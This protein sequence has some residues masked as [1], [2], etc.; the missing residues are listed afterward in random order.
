MSIG[1]FS[2]ATRLTAKALRFYHREGLLEPAVVD[3]SNGYRFYS[4][5]QIADAQAIRA[6]RS[7]HLP[8]DDVRPILA[9]SEPADRS[10]LIAR[11]LAR[12]ET[13]LDETRS[14]V[15]SLRGL[16]RLPDAAIEIEQRTVAPTPAL[17]IRETIDLAD[18]GDW[19]SQTV[20]A[21]GRVAEAS[22]L[23]I[24]GPIGGLWQNDLFLHERGEAAL[25]LPIEPADGIRV[26]RGR[27]EM[28]PAV[29]LA[30]ATHRGSDGG[31]AAVYAAL[32][33]YVADHELG[34]DGPL[35]ETYVRLPTDGDESAVT[36]IGWPIVRTV[37]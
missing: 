34:V 21:L 20:D 19:F 5:E 1:D 10:A 11:H 18:L 16:L 25:Y 13:Q 3:A 37:R 7:M 4:P 15:A 28:L 27:V 31:I 22:A 26:A 23:Q 2:R 8:V 29:D 36:E 17:V 14:I 12:M 24:A 9:T 35:R 30:V 32:G 6:F 33:E